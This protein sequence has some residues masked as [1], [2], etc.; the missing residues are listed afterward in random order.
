MQARGVIDAFDGR[1]PAAPACLC[2]AT[3][4]ALPVLVAAS[5][6]NSHALA[7]RSLLPTQVLSTAPSLTRLA[8]PQGSRVTGSLLQRLPSLV[9]KLRW[10]MQGEE[11]RREGEGEGAPG[12]TAARAVP[13]AGDAGCPAWDS[14]QVGRAGARELGKRV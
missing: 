8:V 6:R 3:G 7:P 11:G 10:G 14:V 1:P 12:D 5:N 2:A 4:V 9:P 13:A